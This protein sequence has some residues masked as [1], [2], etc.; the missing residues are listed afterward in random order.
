MKPAIHVITLAVEDLDRAL[1]FYRVLGF[2]SD[3]IIGTEFV[4]DEVHPSGAIALFR[5]D[6]QVVLSLY[7]RAD[8]AQDAHLGPSP[9]APT[10]FSL[11]HVVAT[12]EEVDAILAAAEAGGAR[13]T[14][15]AH[16]RP[17]G[18]YSGY[19]QDPDGHLWE[20]ICNPGFLEDL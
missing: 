16:D 11:G 3:G 6:R 18:I 14:G 12:R 1:A 19:F 4:G 7:P 20:I 8:L 5:L 17:W 10:E 13:L 15:P 9:P 2:E